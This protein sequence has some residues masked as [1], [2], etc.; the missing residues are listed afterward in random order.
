MVGDKI[1][2]VKNIGWLQILM[3]LIGEI[4]E[5]LKLKKVKIH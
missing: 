1:H 5:P 4:L 2:K 3:V